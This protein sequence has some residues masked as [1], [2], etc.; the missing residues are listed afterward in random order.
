[1]E[2]HWIDKAN[3]FAFMVVN[4]REAFKENDPEEY[5]VVCGDA[6][7]FDRHQFHTEMHR[8]MIR[9]Y[10]VSLDIEN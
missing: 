9:F 4:C 7:G 6:K 10:E 5:E 2:T 8:E 1:A 3:H